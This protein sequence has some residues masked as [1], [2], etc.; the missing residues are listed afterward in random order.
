MATKTA[1]AYAFKAEI[2]QLLN[3]LVHSL[4]KDREIFLRELI[5]NAS[6]ALTRV[7]FEMLTNRDVV[8][9]DAEL[10]IHIDVP[11]VEEGEQ[12]R[13][14]VKDSGVGMTR[15][16]LVQ[17]LGTIAQSG[18]REFLAQVS[19]G[20]MDPSEII[21]QFGV[22]FYSIFMAADRVRVVS[23]SYRP[24]AE[25]AAWTSDGSERFTV[26]AA[27][28]DDRG[29]EIHIFL[30]KDAEEFANAWRLK[31]IVSTYSDFVRFP[32]YV[33][34]EQANQQESLWRKRPSQVEEEDYKS[35]YQQMTMDFEEPL[36]TLHFS[37]DA[38]INVRALLFV[39]AKREQNVLAAR[40]E[41]GVMLYSHNVLIQE[42]CTDLLPEWLGFVDGVVDSE[43]LPLNVSRETVQNN[44]LM[45]RLGALIKKRLFRELD[46]MAEEDPERYETFWHEFGRAFKEG[47]ATDPAAK[48]EVMP[49]L[50]YYSSEEEGLTSLHAYI[51]RMPDSQ[52][53]IYYV[54]GDDRKSAAHSPHLDPLRARGLEALYWVDP[55][56]SLIAPMMQEYEGKSFQNI[57][58][59]DLELPESEE[60]E[61]ETA[62]SETDET[63]AL[64]EKEF[65]QF[66]GR[67]VTTLGDRVIEVRASKVLKDNPVRLVSPKD[68]QN[69]EMHRIYRFVDENYEIP[70]KIMEVNRRHPLVADLAHLIAEQ[71]DSPFIN[72]SIEQLYESALVQEGLH[73][74]PAEMLPRIQELMQLAAAAQTEKS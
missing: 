31:Q 64:P 57:D 29:T 30:K 37:S 35:F 73:P 45:R 32:I 52:E 7:H 72:L 42:Y 56:D 3:I 43:D 18:A 21:G 55:L 13:I 40:K 63:E 39:P 6:D 48:D 41:P 34:E 17:N 11:E 53:Q 4:Y 26:E 69:R 61:G 70:K 62:D 59:A 68:A 24:E 44:R 22:G 20:D 50:R 74:N 19:E 10:A 67:C 38:P 36:L 47:I 12:P 65:N 51:E 2:K 9:P 49:Y 27:E 46:K 15:D 23:R 60:A 8:D 25:A 5:S 28:K 14:V 54:L 58:D 33:G 66:V 1:D 71:P 16:E